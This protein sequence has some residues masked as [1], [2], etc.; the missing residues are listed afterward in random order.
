MN[1]RLPIRIGLFNEKPTSI[2]HHTP[3]VALFINLENATGL[4]SVFLDYNVLLLDS[5]QAVVVC[6]SVC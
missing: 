1:L 5:F 3:R 2:N 4:P 6:C